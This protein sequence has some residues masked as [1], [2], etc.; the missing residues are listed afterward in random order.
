MQVHP[1]ANPEE[2]GSSSEEQEF[3]PAERDSSLEKSESSPEE[4]ESSS[5]E[6]EYSPEDCQ[7]SA[8][9]NVS[10]HLHWSNISSLT[11]L[12]DFSETINVDAPEAFASSPGIQ[13]RTA[14]LHQ[15]KGKG[16]RVQSRSSSE[17]RGSCPEAR[18][19]VELPPP[20][21]VRSNLDAAFVSDFK[22][23][24]NHITNRDEEFPPP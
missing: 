2:R 10:T 9:L 18:P 24:A 3:S 6:R 15:G 5:E 14:F 12:Q 13:S 16:V 4:G 11:M 1:P 23:T 17:V 21:F 8:Q 22:Y 19:G 7:A 20:Y